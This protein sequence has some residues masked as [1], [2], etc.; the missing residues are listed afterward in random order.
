M[1][2]ILFSIVLTL[3]AGLTVSAQNQVN[4][5]IN[6]LLD[7]ES[8]SFNKAFHNNL[9]DE[10]YYNRLQYYISGVSLVH[11][12]GTETELA[13]FYA[14]IT[15]G[16]AEST[17][18]DF[19]TQEISQIEKVIFHIGIDED[20]NHA[21][22]SLYEVDHPLALQEPSMHWGWAGGYRFIVVEGNTGDTFEDPVALHCIGDKNY[23][24]VEL[25]IIADA[26]DGIINIE[27]YAEY[28][29][30]L[31]DISVEGGVI[32]HGDLL[33]IVD[34]VENFENNIFRS[35]IA[36]VNILNSEEINQFSV[37]PN[38]TNTGSFNLNIDSEFT[39]TRAEL[40]DLQGKM[41]Q[42]FSIQNGMNTLQYD[43]K[44]MYILSVVN[45][46]NKSIAYKKLIIQ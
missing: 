17:T 21:D 38:P 8:L 28:Q 18:L 43:H 2:G 26:I 1:K 6:H 16:D 34:L 4:L 12:G 5:T 27:I 29:N 3:L 44:G 45:S 20:T 40:Y 35:T 36:P 46:E 31:K 13:D 37:Y 10:L 39:Q 14:L 24:D 15:C 19:G 22:P 30:A 32:M 41:V 23:V 11:D 33:E 42:S 25:D 7:G 9:D